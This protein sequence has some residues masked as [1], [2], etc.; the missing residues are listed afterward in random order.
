M[1]ETRA[2]NGAMPP[3]DLYR[4]RQGAATDEDG[5]E[6]F[7]NAYQRRRRQP[8]V[9]EEATDQPSP[10]SPPSPP[11]PLNDPGV[12]SDP[13]LLALDRQVAID[14]TPEVRVHRGERAYRRESPTG[15]S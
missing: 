14:G 9:E 2:L 8:A 13:L 11:P 12:D 5:G 4:T 10:P 15:H 1:D 7:G 6:S 3:V